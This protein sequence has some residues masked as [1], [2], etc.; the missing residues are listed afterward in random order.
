MKHAVFQVVSAL[1]AI[2][3]AM[4][5]LGPF[6]YVLLRSFASWEGVSFQPY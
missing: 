5:S 1:F 2:L 4:A 3:L 6:C